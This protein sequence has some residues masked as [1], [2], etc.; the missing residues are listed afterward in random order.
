MDT[1][2]IIEAVL[3]EARISKKATV[4]YDT[5]EHWLSGKK[6]VSLET[7]K[8]ANFEQLPENQKAS[9]KKQYEE[10]KAE[11]NKEVEEAKKKIKEKYKE[12][13]YPEHKDYK[14]SD[15]KLKSK[16]KA[17]GTDAKRDFK[18]NYE[19]VV[20]DLAENFL[21]AYPGIKEFLKEKHIEEKDHLSY[22]ADLFPS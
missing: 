11:R 17:W 8:P 7:N 4:K 9:I 15:S 14:W 5:L 2:H 16:I 12:T 3:K 20:H 1:L 13:Q 22:I 6:F 10:E 19:D 21:L 18:D